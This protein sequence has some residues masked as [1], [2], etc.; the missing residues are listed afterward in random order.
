M[1]SS[2]ADVNFNTYSILLK[3]L[4]SAGNWRKYI[5]VTYRLSSV[6]LVNML[7]FSCQFYTV[8][9]ASSCFLVAHVLMAVVGHFILPFSCFIRI[10]VPIQHCGMQ[11][12]MLHFLNLMLVN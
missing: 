7:L 9:V 11:A 10:A 6:S 4:L 2:G 3:N 5:E 12:L 8:R 1:V